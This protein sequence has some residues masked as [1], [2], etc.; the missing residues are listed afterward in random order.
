MLACFGLS[1]GESS[2]LQQQTR[3]AVELPLPIPALVNFDTDGGFVTNDSHTVVSAVLRL[4]ALMPAGELRLRIF[5][6][7]KLGSSITHLNDLA[8]KSKTAITGSKIYTTQKEFET[9]LDGMTQH[10]AEVT[11]RYLGSRHPSLRSYNELAGETAEAYRL[12][13]VLDY[14]TGI[15]APSG[16][17][18]ASV[19]ARLE[20][21][22]KTGPRCGVYTIVLASHQ[23][24]SSYA[25][26][27]HDSVPDVPAGLPVL[28]SGTTHA[29]A[30]SYWPALTRG[31]LMGASQ[32]Q[33]VSSSFVDVRDAVVRSNYKAFATITPSMQ[34]IATVRSIDTI[35]ADALVR[36][37]DA[38]VHRVPGVSVDPNSVS[39]LARSSRDHTAVGATAVADPQSIDTWWRRNAADGVR[40]TIGRRGDRGVAELLFGSNEPA[41]LIG[42]R[43]GSGKSVLLH[44]VICDI[45]RN[46]SPADVQLYL[47]D[48]K[49]GV[50]FNVY[51]QAKLPHAAVVT[52][53]SAPECTLAIL[54]TLLDKMYTRGKRF[55]DAGV[56]KIDDYR[57]INRG[58]PMPRIVVIVDEFQKLLDTG[59]DTT[60]TRAADVINRIIREGRA[61]G[62]HLVLA[63]QSLFGVS[64]LPSA[65]G[66]IST[67]VALRM[68]DDD[69][70]RVLGDTMGDAANLTRTGQA[71][72]QSSNDTFQIQVTHETDSTIAAT[73]RS[74]RIVAAAARMRSTGPKVIDFSTPTLPG[75]AVARALKAVRQG[76]RITFPLSVHYGLE[77]AQTVSFTATADQNLLVATPSSYDDTSTSTAVALMGMLLAGCVRSKISFDVIDF[78]PLGSAF[79]ADLATI[80]TAARLGPGQRFHEQR[81]T[82][83]ALLSVARVVVDRKKTPRANDPHV[84]YLG[85]VNTAANL[86]SARGGQIHELA[87][88][89]VNNGP[90][91]GVHVVVTLDSYRSFENTLGSQMLSAFGHKLLGKSSPDDA[92]A[93]CGD[94]GPSRLDRGELSYVNPAGEFTKTQAFATLPPTFWE[95]M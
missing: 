92:L 38:D 49:Q 66:M 95:R 42:G 5:D 16:S 68:S 18:D 31:S 90:A 76:N 46:Y 10:I 63:T 85:H 34:W 87:T 94:Y 37:L 30:P 65:I 15:Q 88:K 93:L 81:D 4:V 19:L 8:D 71:I 20:T 36:R 61:F 12:L 89:I 77:P 13:V 56:Q 3:T 32:A 1:Q 14:P 51:A 79:A 48:P 21:I 9:L 39:T 82:V 84:V 75:G 64:N 83:A 62:I 17:V 43:P 52:V 57:P 2:Y 29:E 53:S 35:A 70:R 67:R 47:L 28:L 69:S 50:E 55:R 25:S 74:A 44:A 78:S 80:A 6:P 22:I 45:A 11:Q 60:S 40:V 33:P 27:W 91:V 58:N 54:Q 26:T 59:D 41:T 72:L 7:L 73:V 86:S 23:R 24:Q